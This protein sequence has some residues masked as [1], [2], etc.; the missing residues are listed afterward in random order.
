MDLPLKVFTIGHTLLVL[1]FLLYSDSLFP[2]AAAQPAN[3]YY[4]ASG[5]TDGKCPFTACLDN[6]AAH[7]YRKGCAF[8]SS[9]ACA[10]CT[11]LT[12]GYYFSATGHFTDSCTKTQC[13]VCPV[14]QWN[15]GC[16]ATSAGTCVPCTG[17]RTT[18]EY[19][20]TNALVTDTCLVSTCQQ[21]CGPG[22]YRK[23]CGGAGTTNA[24][25]AGTCVDCTSP[26]IPAGSYYSGTGGLTNNCVISVCNLCTA[27]VMSSN[28]GGKNAGSCDVQCIGLP[29]GSYYL[30][31]TTALDACSRTGLQTVC[32]AG[33]RN[34]GYSR[35]SAGSCSACPA[36]A[37]GTYWI[38]NPNVTTNCVTDSCKDSNCAVGEWKQGCTGT[39]AGA[40]APCT[41]A[42]P[43][44][45][46]NTRG[47]YG[48]T[49]ACGVVGC[50]AAVCAVGKYLSGCTGTAPGTCASCTDPG[51][52]KYLYTRGAYTADSCSSA[53][54]A[55]CGI[56]YY[57]TGCGGTSEGSCGTCTNTVYP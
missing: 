36:Q 35:T 22:R 55:S 7:Q 5:G 24:A 19:Y 54:C 44:S 23:D 13:T 18:T 49:S 37:A 11:G 17:T 9:G 4:T 52:T 29:Y 10:P 51:L 6:C 20:S 2:L 14:G 31:P 1:A 27:G 41:N 8:N 48:S 43:N 16:S 32:P 33:Q 34:S 3:S 38:A 28:C 53:T 45:Y 50:N 46:Y 56:G 40:C 42:G 39:S 47:G 26:T 21:D 12:S 15:S 30:A 57:R 25:N